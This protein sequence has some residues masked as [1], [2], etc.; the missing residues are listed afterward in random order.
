MIE[1]TGGDL[2]SRPCVVNGCTASRSV[3]LSDSHVIISP[4]PGFMPVIPRYF[5]QMTI[6][7][8]HRV[9]HLTVDHNL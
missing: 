8:H 2:T 5:H 7:L 4:N 3:S 9:I 1:L 6:Y